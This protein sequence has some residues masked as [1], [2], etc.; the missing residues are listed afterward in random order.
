M[1]E[2][3]ET[4]KPN[5][6]RITS[7]IIAVVMLIGAFAVLI[8]PIA[9]NVSAVADVHT[10]DGG[11]AGNLASADDNWDTTAPDTG[12]TVVFNA[13]SKACTWDIAKTFG[14]FY[15]NASYTGV[16][17]Q[18]ST[19]GVSSFHMATGTFTGSIS[20]YVMDSGDFIQTGGVISNNV[21][22]VN[23]TGTSK[24]LSP[25]ATGGVGSAR[26]LFHEIHISGTITLTETCDAYD[27][28]IIDSGKTLSISTGK[29]L[30]HV[31]YLTPIS[32]AGTITGLGTL[33]ETFATS[34]ALT[35]GTVQCPVWLLLND[36][37]AASRIASLSANTSFASTV[38][39]DSDHGTYTL[40]LNH[41]DNYTLNI[42]STLTI[43]TR[44]AVT[45]GTGT[46]IIAS[47]VETAASS[48]LTLGG[49]LVI[50]D[51]S[52]D[53]PCNF[54]T[55][56]GTF[57]PGTYTT[58]LAGKTGYAKLKSTQQFDE[59]NIYG[60][61]T[62][63]RLYQS[64][65]R[66][67]DHLVV[68][69]GATAYLEQNTY[70]MDSAQV[71]G[72]LA[73]NG[74]R[75]NISGAQVTQDLSGTFDGGICLNGSASSIQVQVGSGMGYILANK[76]VNLT[77]SGK[78]LQFTPQ[79]GQFV[80]ISGLVMGTSPSWIAASWNG[81]DPLK[82]VT[83]GDS[84]TNNERESHGGHSWPYYLNQLLSPDYTVVNKGLGGS[85][86]DTEITNLAGHMAGQ[87]ADIV[88][89]MIGHNDILGD[90]MDSYA[91]FIGE[92]ETLITAILAYNVQL[93]VSTIIVSSNPYPSVEII[94]NQINDWIMAHADITPLNMSQ[95]FP[96]S[97]ITSW[98]DDNV[99]LSESAS[100][101]Y[102]NLM[103]TNFL[104]YGNITVNFTVSGLEDGTW[105]RLFIDGNPYQ[106]LIATG[107]SV[108]FIYSGPWS[109][110]VFEIHQTSIT[111]SIGPLVKLIFIMFAIGVVVG[112][113]AEGTYSIRKNKMLSTPEMMKLLFN[114][115]I[116]IVIGIASLGVLY[117]IV[118]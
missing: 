65:G 80:N 47:L 79:A 37:S 108:S 112:V 104:H 68:A 56:N 21:L 33:K 102:A 78:S 49:A 118:V 59:V 4:R 31:N 66:L 23:M 20:Y 2:P 89:L 43:G 86:V 90:P 62:T 25:F 18:T 1:S 32:N 44:G 30:N 7:I 99:H 39:V 64:S 6:F 10:W 106:I 28:L 71:A 92:M 12:D 40:T 15:I 105:Y 103:A 3:Q 36:G 13:G 16:I 116:Y 38:R 63:K 57:T 29:V 48:T 54:D 60:A 9:I 107:G 34:T 27:T 109:V 14:G 111:G 73:Q 58:Y 115:L 53:A 35:M 96:Y 19:F 82:I 26:V 11:D 46:W 22:V 77:M 114:M 93:Y 17:T 83:L 101:Y 55:F 74:Y 87:N 117:S 113:I 100:V 42:G 72:T 97:N 75:L 52:L 69:T 50:G 51:L 88:I 41:G 98:S 24:V 67:A 5:R 94:R 76:T 110:H 70:V 91:H 61:L 45:T 95:Y 84:L 85:T 8:S 81:A